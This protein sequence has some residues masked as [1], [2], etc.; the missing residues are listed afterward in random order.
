MAVIGDHEND[1]PISSVDVPTA[2]LLLDLVPVFAARRNGNREAMALRFEDVDG[3]I[4]PPDTV[5]RPWG[6]G[7]PSATALTL[8]FRT[9]NR[10]VPTGTVQHMKE[11]AKAT[12]AYERK[13][14][15]AGGTVKL[16]D[17]NGSSL[18]RTFSQKHKVF[19][20]QFSGTIKPPLAT[21]DAWNRAPMRNLI[22]RDNFPRVQH[23]VI[24]RFL[25][26]FGYTRGSVE[27]REKGQFRAVTMGMKRVA[28]VTSIPGFRYTDPKMYGDKQVIFVGGNIQRSVWPA[29][30]DKAP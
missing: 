28:S 21:S 26:R 10:E 25:H 20:P 12:L 5:D 1:E 18:F 29:R 23:C 9:R 4:L 22:R 16:R 14:I 24:L 15:A 27:Q 13:L 7:Y 8:F 11:Q 17:P 30:G 19:L 3:A 6:R 2:E